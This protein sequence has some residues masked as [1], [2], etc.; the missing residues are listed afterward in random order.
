MPEMKILGAAALLV[1]STTLAS[2]TPATLQK[3]AKLRAGPG[4]HYPGVAPLPRRSAVE[5]ETCTGSWCRVESALGSG[6]LAR[7]V[8]ALRGVPPAVAVVP[9]PREDY[10]YDDYPGFDY[11]GYAYGPAAGVYV[12]PRWHHHGRGWH[13]RPPAWA[14]RP[15]Q[16]WEGPGPIPGQA[17]VNKS[18]GQVGRPGGFGGGGAAIGGS[19]PMSGTFG[20]AAPAPGAAAIAPAAPAVAPPASVAPMGKK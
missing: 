11:P 4:T 14:G 2:A 3:G 13:H 15:T 10:Y 17:P 18:F 12:P 16:P 1:L 19:R 5:V 9:A 20:T 7:A 6:Y 8:L